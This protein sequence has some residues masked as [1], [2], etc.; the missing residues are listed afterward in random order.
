MRKLTER[1]VL[2]LAAERLGRTS[3]PQLVRLSV[4]PPLAIQWLM[5]GL[6][7]FNQRNPNVHVELRQFK[8]CSQKRWLLPKQAWAALSLKELDTGYA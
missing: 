5:P 2:A 8:K 6:P 1:H 7:E 4:T 3:V